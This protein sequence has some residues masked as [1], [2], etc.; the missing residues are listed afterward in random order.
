M[1]GTAW[2]RARYAAATCA[3]QNAGRRQFL[4][5]RQPRDHGQLRLDRRP[6][7]L[8]LPAPSE[9]RVPGKVDVTALSLSAVRLG[10]CI[11]EGPRQWG[12]RQSP[13]RD[14]AVRPGAAVDGQ[15]AS[16]AQAV[17]GGHGDV[18]AGELLVDHAV[19]GERAGV[20]EHPARVAGCCTSRTVQSSAHSGSVTQPGWTR[21]RRPD[22]THRS[23]D[24]A[25][26]ARARAGSEAV[27]CEPRSA[28][29]SCTRSACRFRACRRDRRVASVDEPPGG[30]PPGQR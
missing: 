13:G 27:R 30:A 6:P 15:P 19:Q 12:G 7:G 20:A 3:P 22:A 18:E 17:A 5:P 16:G 8:A 26:A 4:R 9:E 11:D 14:H 23:T 29:R 2:H 25:D 28:G 24:R 10:P 21:T 1:P